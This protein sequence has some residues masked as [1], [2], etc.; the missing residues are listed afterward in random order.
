[1]TLSPFSCLYWPLSPFHLACSDMYMFASV[2]ISPHAASV[3]YAGF[4]A[5]VTTPDGTKTYIAYP[6]GMS[7]VRDLPFSPFSAISIRLDPIFSIALY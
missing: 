1:M 7:M 3:Y 6:W 2:V 4:N 5:A